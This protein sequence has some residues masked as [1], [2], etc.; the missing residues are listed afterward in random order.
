MPRLSGLNSKQKKAFQR[1][2]ELLRQN[3]RDILWYHRVGEQVNRLF[4]DYDRGYGERYIEGLAEDLE[5]PRTFADKLWKARVFVQRYSR[6]E[7]RDLLK[8]KESGYFLRWSHIVHLL[9]LDDGDVPD[10][11]EQCLENEWSVKEL[12]NRIKEHRKPQGKG[13][14]RFKRP[15]DVETALRQ[16]TEETRKWLRQHDKVWFHAD[17]PAIPSEPEKFQSQEVGTLVAQAADV[18]EMLQFKLKDALLRV[19]RLKGPKPKTKKKKNVKK[20]R[21]RRRRIG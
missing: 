15:K 14:R 17:E 3:D 12:H 19:K 7:V 5:M 11:Q 6:A 8:P 1:L 18:L 10:F 16:L 21:K 20:M 4:P 13:G 2:Q 9:S